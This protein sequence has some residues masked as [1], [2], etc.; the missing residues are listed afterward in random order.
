MSERDPTR[1][2]ARHA[3]A[4]RQNACLGTETLAGTRNSPRK[5][6]NVGIG[7]RGTGPGGGGGGRRGRGAAAPSAPA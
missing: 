1:M 5:L 2:P 6:G 4:I 3:S 7:G